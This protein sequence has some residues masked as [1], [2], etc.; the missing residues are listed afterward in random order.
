V[1]SI[2]EL[3]TQRRWLTS[4]EIVISGEPGKGARRASASCRPAHLACTVSRAP[5]E[6]VMTQI[7][8]AVRIA[9]PIMTI[10]DDTPVSTL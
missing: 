7:A 6:S 10:I 3:S 2:H 1:A 8:M 5:S 9:N 4:P